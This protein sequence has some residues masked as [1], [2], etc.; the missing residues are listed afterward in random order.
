M[1]IPTHAGAPKGAPGAAHDAAAERAA[2]RDPGA[3]PPGRPASAAADGPVPPVPRLKDQAARLR[4]RAQARGEAMSHAQSLEALARLMGRA[5]WN[6]LR[7]AAVA[8]PAGAPLAA[9]EK[10]WARYMGSA[11]I[12]AKVLAVRAGAKPGLWRVQIAFAEALEQR[13]GRRR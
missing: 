10:V 9:E 7:A 13:P 4:A 1:R 8:G 3:R 11:P 2:E 5:D 12:K 6:T